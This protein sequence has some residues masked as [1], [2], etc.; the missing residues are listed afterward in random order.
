MD[1]KSNQPTGFNKIFGSGPAGLLVSVTLFIVA[2]WLNKR[3]NPPPL[4]NSRFFL[5]SIFIVSILVTLTVIVWSIKS[6]SASERGNKLCISGVFKYVRHPLYAAFLSIFNF[7]LAFY[8]N[9]Y[10]FVLWALFL[11]PICHY[12]VRYEERMMIDAF[13]DA[14]IEYQR[15]TGRFFPRFGYKK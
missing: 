7:G 14:Y 5:G 2:N 10:I 4:S 9:S 1:N 8:L 11:H 13:G 12:L 15:K 3:I 6:L